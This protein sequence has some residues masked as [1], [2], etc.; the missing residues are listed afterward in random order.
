M[1]L[2]LSW[3]QAHEFVCRTS[4]WPLVVRFYHVQFQTGL[5]VHGILEDGG[6][7]DPDKNTALAATLRTAKAFGIPKDNIERALAKVPLQ[8]YNYNVFTQVCTQAS[9]GKDKGSQLMTYEA[10]AHGVVGVIM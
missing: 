8:I 7:P 1:Y 3:R 6:S 4:L 9:G 5:V 10:L 2:V